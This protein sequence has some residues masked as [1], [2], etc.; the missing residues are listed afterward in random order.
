MRVFSYLFHGLLTLFLLGISV[1]AL[2]SGQP[3]TLEMLPWQGPALTW[4][5]LGAAMAGL[6]SVILAIRG[7]WRALFFLWSLAVLAITVRG[8]FFSH[9]YF[10]GPPEFHQ[11]LY[12]TAG[13]LIAAVGAW[14]QLYR[15]PLR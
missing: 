14:F 2:S 6:A 4:W 3:L 5:L 9:Y 7:K 15:V 11:A 13:A 1:V 10:A 12:L 8:F